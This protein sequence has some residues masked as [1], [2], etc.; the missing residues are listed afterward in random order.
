MSTIRTNV[1]EKGYQRHPLNVRL[2]DCTNPWDLTNDF[3]AV[4][5]TSALFGTKIRTH[6]SGHVHI[7]DYSCICIQRGNPGINKI[8]RSIYAEV[9]T[10]KLHCI[11][12]TALT[13][14]TIVTRTMQCSV[15]LVR[16]VSIFQ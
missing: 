13:D 11:V 1:T 2:Y 9:G 16:R 5:L 12:L 7:V 14:P 10:I 3:H 8:Q 4:L 15:L 6:L